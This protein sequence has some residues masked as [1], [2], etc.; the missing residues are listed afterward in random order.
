MRCRTTCDRLLVAA[1][2]HRLP[3]AL[4]ND[5]RSTRCGTTSPHLRYGVR[6]SSR[7]SITTSRSVCVRRST[8]TPMPPTPP[9]PPPPSATARPSARRASPDPARPS[10]PPSPRADDSR[11]APSRRV[12][13]ASCRRCAR[14]GRSC[15]RSLLVPPT[16]A[17]VAQAR[18]A[19]RGRP[20]AT[21]RAMGRAR[22]P[23]PPRRSQPPG[24]PPRAAATAESQQSDAILRK[25]F[26]CRCRAGLLW[27][28]TTL[29]WLALAEHYPCRRE[30]P[31]GREATGKCP[32]CHR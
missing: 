24:R 12:G 29:L 23:R 27:L 3:H 4:L 8:T 30:L 18:R 9:P 26:A 11:A 19:L 5:V 22:P 17:G 16:A 31:I 21:G 20:R 1:P 25:N 13:R 15:D 28:A 2:T 32:F 7:L 6:R 14:H 10:P